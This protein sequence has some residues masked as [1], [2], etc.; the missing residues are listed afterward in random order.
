VVT[1]SPAG[2]EVEVIY[3]L[4]RQPVNEIFSTFKGIIIFDS[5]WFRCP[6]IIV[7]FFSSSALLSSFAF[8]TMTMGRAAA[9]LSVAV[10]DKEVHSVAFAFRAVNVKSLGSDGPKKPYR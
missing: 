1:K 7:V 10:A 3:S 8:T 6:R 2:F 5:H 4:E 9:G